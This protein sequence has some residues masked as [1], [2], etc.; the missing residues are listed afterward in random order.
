[1]LCEETSTFFIY[2]IALTLKVRE[3]AA[4]KISCRVAECL[5]IL[6]G[7]NWLSFQEQNLLAY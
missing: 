5:E 3:S 4:N 6:V 1:M 7:L 2:I